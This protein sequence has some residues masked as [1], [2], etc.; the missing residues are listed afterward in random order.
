MSHTRLC[1][2]H[3]RLLSLRQI[4]FKSVRMYS[5]CGGV[6]VAGG[7]R[8]C[9]SLKTVLRGRS[10]LPQIQ[11]GAL[12]MA[13][14]LDAPCT[15]RC[16]VRQHPCSQRGLR[17]GK[18]TLGQV[19]HHVLQNHAGNPKSPGLQRAMQPPAKSRGLAANFHPTGRVNLCIGR[20]LK[21]VFKEL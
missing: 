8:A 1:Y 21:T 16:Y 14:F 10:P 9:R 19:P 5:V 4:F 17:A 20:L 7:D 6:C 12:F 2:T 3:A 15:G 18:E 11:K 13:K